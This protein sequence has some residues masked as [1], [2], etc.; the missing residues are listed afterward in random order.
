MEKKF[1][2]FNPNPTA[3]VDKK[4]GKP[5]RW[6]KGDCVI[7][8]FCGVLNSTWDIVYADMCKLGAKYHD[9]PNSHSIIDK[10]AK[11]NGLIKESLP[12]YM[13]VKEF[14]ETH[15]GTYLIN[16]RSHVACI[17]GNMIN[18]TW[19]CGNYKMKTYYVKY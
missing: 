13:T 14:A 2:Y 19:N 12:Y 3:K 11:K 18:D 16:V 15:D 10:Y 5:K 1:I 8:A 6:N 9:M 17:K 7:R 4:T